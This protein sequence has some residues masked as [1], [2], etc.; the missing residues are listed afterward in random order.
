VH[1][2]GYRSHWGR[3]RVVLVLGAALALA[4]CG[5]SARS[6]NSMGDPEESSGAGGVPPDPSQGGGGM[7]AFATGGAGAPAT[8]GAGAPAMCGAGASATGGNEDADGGGEPCT[9]ASEC[10]PDLTCALGACRTECRTDADCPRGVLCSGTEPPYGCALPKELDCACPSDC[11]APL[12]CARDGK[13]RVGCE[14]SDD[15][16]RNDHTCRTGV[17]VGDDDPDGRWFECEDGE[18]VCENYLTGVSCGG[19]GFPESCYRRMGCRVDGMN[20]GLI[21]TCSPGTCVM[22]LDPDGWLSSQCR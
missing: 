19:A 5:K 22:K 17:C 2:V 6:G 14:G 4:A 12:V 3:H 18:T 21:E 9:T 11:P 13:C 8:G 10:G 16:P 7:G 1:A 15:C 20:W